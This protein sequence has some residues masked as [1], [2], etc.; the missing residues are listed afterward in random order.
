MYENSND[1]IYRI[2]IVSSS[3]F[4]LMIRRPPRS[5]RTDTLFPY[6]T[7]FRSRIAGLVGL[8]Q[9]LGQI[10]TLHVGAGVTVKAHR[11]HVEEHRLA[12]A[13]REVRRFLR[14]GIGRNQVAAVAADIV[15]PGAAPE[16]RRDPAAW[17]AG[18]N[19]A[20]IILA[21]DNTRPRRPLHPGP[22]P[23]RYP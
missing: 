15:Q 11:G 6:T 1:T 13:P 21:P 9:R 17:G 18:R 10:G 12:G 16:L 23:G 4:F 19:A 3:I 20:A 14:A 8:D 5:T 2:C 22:P 7:L